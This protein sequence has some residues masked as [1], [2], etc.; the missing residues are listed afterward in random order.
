MRCIG[1]SSEERVATASGRTRNDAAARLHKLS[2]KGLVTLDPGLFGGWGLTD[3][4]R[5]VERELVRDEL[6]TTGASDHVRRMYESFLDLNP[7]LLQ[8]CT[9]WQMRKVGVSHLVNDHHD[10][11]YDAKVLSR[12][13]R[14]DQS[15]QVI[16][17]QLATRLSRF[18]VYG[19]RLSHAIERAVTGDPAYVADSLESYHAV[20]F[21]LHEDLL[22]TLG[23]SRD[24]ERG[25]GSASV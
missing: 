16:C 7:K 9:D 14:I 3:D 5:S 18:G 1:I 12:L 20:W 21:Q 24:Q 17:D 11:D 19:T 25:N 22:V 10:P 2:S 15:A 13:M 8:I 6:E 4:G 23:I